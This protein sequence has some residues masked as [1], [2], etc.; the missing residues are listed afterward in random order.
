MTVT[1]LLCCFTDAD[2]EGTEIASGTLTDSMRSRDITIMT[3]SNDKLEENRDFTIVVEQTTV[4]SPLVKLQS[5]TA[6]VVIL[7]DD[8]GMIG[9]ID[10]SN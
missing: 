9:S 1:G 2:F 8:I 7:D 5:A 6:S 10:R 3:K 4:N